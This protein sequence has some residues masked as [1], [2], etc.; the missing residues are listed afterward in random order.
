M[1]GPPRQPLHAGKVNFSISGVRSRGA[2]QVDVLYSLTVSDASALD[3]PYPLIGQALLIQG[4]WKANGNYACGL[5]ALAGQ[6]CT[7]PSANGVP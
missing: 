4:G 1:I 5:A 2:G 3:T 6:G 7:A